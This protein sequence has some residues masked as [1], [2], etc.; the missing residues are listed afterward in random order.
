LLANA[1]TKLLADFKATEPAKAPAD[2]K[3]Y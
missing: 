1:T 3:V 2:A